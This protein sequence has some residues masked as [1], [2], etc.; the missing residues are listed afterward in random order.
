VDD[1]S[2]DG[3]PDVLAA[4]VDARLRLLRHDDSRG[5]AS[6]RNAGVAVAQGSWIAFLD[7]DDLWAP[8]KLRI[9]I[10]AADSEG[11]SFGY[12]GA[13]AVAEDRTWR[14]SLAPPDPALLAKTLLAR[15]VLW[16]GSSNVIARSDLVRRLGGFDERLFQ[17][18][19][20][21]L[22][23][24]LSQAGPAVACPE[25]LVACTEHRR[26]MLLTS[27]DDVF[28]E[29]EYLEAKHRA[30]RVIHGVR[31]DRRIFERWVGLGH[32]RAGRRFRAARVYVGGAVRNR[33][34][35]DLARAVAAPFGERPVEWARRALGRPRPDE[36]A[37]GLGEP[38]WLALYR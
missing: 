3:T 19:D 15:N 29:F 33:D 20:W 18:C 7:D 30:A 11:A 22:W 4:L 21:D 36:S 17:L 35:G 38:S 10:D 14:Y 23:I 8:R 28:A 26:S 27:D 25:V 12:G 6:A 5:V 9:Q 32:R 37:H 13:A 34:P 16:G 2:T 1:G 31:L 24:R